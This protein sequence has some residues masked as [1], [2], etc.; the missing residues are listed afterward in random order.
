MDLRTYLIESLEY[1]SVYKKYEW[2]VTLF[3]TTDYVEDWRAGSYPYR[4]VKTPDQVYYVSPD[5]PET[6]VP[7]DG[8]KGTDALV[9][10][11]DVIRV[12]AGEVFSIK[13]PMDV[14]VGNLFTN[15]LLYR[16]AFGDKIPFNNGSIKGNTLEQFFSDNLVD[17]PPEGVEKDPSKIYI[18]DFLVYYKSYCY[19]INF[20]HL[21]VPG[22]SEKSLQTHPDMDRRRAELFEKHKH[23]LNDPTVVTLIEN[24][25]SNLDREWLAGDPATGLW[26]SDKDF[27]VIRK[28]L[29]I[30]FGRVTAFS[31]TE[32][33]KLITK[34]L[35]E[36]WDLA[37]FKYYLNDSRAG[38]FDRGAS[39]ALGGEFAKWILR[40]S[41]NIHILDEDCG[42]TL[43]DRVVIDAVNYKLYQGFYYLNRKGS[44]V[45][46][47]VE[48]KES[49]F[50]KRMIIRSPRFCRGKGGYFCRVC[51]GDKLSEHPA[52]VSM[53]LTKI[54]NDIMGI[55]MSSMHG[56]IAQVA[57]YDPIA[58]LS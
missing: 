18:S 10:P 54:G 22:D 23:E 2:I 12:D 1:G 32:A 57:S 47:D 26:M 27:K 20:M 6:L 48:R 11:K 42:S 45:P 31:E 14:T 43:G 24:E 15:Y 51:M 58:E 17:D 39:T 55:F 21:F 28:R 16:D 30:D 4:L 52:G 50:G 5:N 33:P 44:P 25:L 56:R 29:Y 3:A 40:V 36:G 9:T 35:S 19:L 38:S 37:N 8:F 13:E 41:S 46:F 49:Y 7:I 34:P 53:A